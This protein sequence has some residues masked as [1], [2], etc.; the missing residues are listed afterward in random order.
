MMCATMMRT[1]VL[2]G[3]NEADARCLAVTSRGVMTP[4][5]QHQSRGLQKKQQRGNAARI[6][7]SS[8]KKR[9]GHQETFS[10]LR[11]RPDGI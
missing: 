8:C 11:V 4:N 5:V 9:F 1:P 7:G 6:G 3:C 10:T 2:H